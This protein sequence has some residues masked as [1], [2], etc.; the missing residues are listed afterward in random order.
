MSRG[1]AKAKA[2]AKAVVA[3]KMPVIQSG[4]LP[5]FLVWP[6]FL[7]LP[8]ICLIGAWTTPP[9]ATPDELKAAASQILLTLLLLVWLLHRR[10]VSLIELRFSATTYA[11]AALFIVGSLSVIWSANPDFWFYKWSRWYAG[12]VMFLF[13]MQ[14]RQ[15]SMNLNRLIMACLAAGVITAV[16]GIAQQVFGFSLIPQ[17]AFPA[18]TFGNGNVAG[19]VMIFTL[20]LGLYFMFRDDLSSRGAWLTSTAICLIAIYAFYTRTRA[21]WIAIILEIGLIGLFIV[22]DPR[23]ASWLHWNRTKTFASLALLIVFLGMINIGRDGNFAPF[24]RV[25]A[26]EFTSIVPEIE[27]SQGESA[28]ARYLIWRSTLEMIKDSP[29]I[30]TGVGSFFEVMNNGGYNNLNVLGVQRVHNDVLELAVDLGAIGLLCLIAIIVTFCRTL[31]LLLLHSTGKHRLIYALLTIA[32]T[33]SMLDAQLAFP[34]EMPVP[35][36]M[37]PLFM[38]LVIRGGEQVQPSIVRTVRIG[39]WFNH[40]SIGACITMLLI[41]TVI[42]IQ[43]LRDFWQMNKVLE[44]PSA[45]LA[46]KPNSLVMSQAHI[47]GGRSAIDALMSVGLYPTAMSILRP[48]LDY[49][50]ETLAHTMSM[51]RIS[52]SMGNLQEAEKWAQKT[53]EVQPDGTFVGELYLLDIY[54]ELGDIE[55]VTAIYDSLKLLPDDKVSSYANTVNALHFNSIALNDTGSTERFYNL[56]VQHFGLMAGIEANHAVFLMNNDRLQEAFVHMQRALTLDSEIPQAAGFRQILTENG[57]Q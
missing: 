35:L 34:Y 6:I 9:L 44:D 56:Y 21:V 28:S 19:E 45:N 12:F 2:K 51:V 14:L 50:P 57:V 43:W 32:V 27:N 26:F 36:V 13:G 48:I 39:R 20:P 7:I 8:L 30:G 3:D 15:N 29:V 52:T 31:Y 41:V 38:A 37:M 33:G 18:S 46:W 16:V 23:R 42:N 11:F 47:T 4:S 5:D 10:E 17:T 22:F 55:K 49:W 24:W 54:S 25:A 1:K 40:G 53:V